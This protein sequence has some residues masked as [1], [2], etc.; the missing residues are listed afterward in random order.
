MVMGFDNGSF[1]KWL[2]HDTEVLLNGV[3]ALLKQTN[4]QTNKPPETMSIPLL[5]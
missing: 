3:S 4:K 5:P 2:S 1:G